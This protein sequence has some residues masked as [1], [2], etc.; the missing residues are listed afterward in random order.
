MRLTSR[1][2]L[3]STLALA[4]AIALVACSDA[5]PL[6]QGS[7][8]EQADAV[9]EKF[10]ERRR[11]IRDELGEDPTRDEV[12]TAVQEDVI[13]SYRDQLEELRALEPVDTDRL[14]VAEIWDDYAHGIDEF[15]REAR[16]DI[17]TALTEEPEG[18][19]RA[20]EAAADF[21]MEVCSSQ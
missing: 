14:T 20:R 21:G 13:P 5:G 3:V 2:L 7:Y 10:N 9:C 12:A 4:A 8:A 16:D 11:E 17:E 19:T 6:D 18:I 15:A 1:P